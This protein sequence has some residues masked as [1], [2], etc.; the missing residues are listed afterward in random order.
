VRCKNKKAF[1]IT[2]KLFNYLRIVGDNAQQC[3]EIK[4]AF[5]IT[6]RLVKIFEVIA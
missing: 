2:E 5:R 3:Q 1:R 4:K 6:E